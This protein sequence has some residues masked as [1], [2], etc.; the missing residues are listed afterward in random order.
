MALVRL[1]LDTRKASRNKNG[2]YPI[3][4]K[5]FHL[6]PR[7]IRLGHFTSTDGWDDKN[8]TLRKSVRA[9][10][11]Q[12]CWEIEEDIED[13][14]FKAKRIIRELGRKLEVIDVDRLVD[15]I[16]DKWDE[17]PDS[18]LRKRIENN[19]T[20]LTWAKVLNTR[21]RNANR[22]GTGRWY[23]AGVEA[24]MKFNNGRDIAL[25][26]INVTFL[27]NF[28]A[29][30]LGKGN[31]K[32][33][34]GIYLKAIRVIYNSAIAEDQFVPFKNAFKHYRIPPSTR[35]K[36]R[37]IL[38]EKLIKI[39]SLLYEKESP[40]WHAKNYALIMFYCRGMNFVDLVKIKVKDISDGRLYYGRSKTDDSFSVKITEELSNI[41]VYYLQGKKPNDYLLPTNYDGSTKHFQKYKSQRRRMNERLRIIAADAGIDG[42][43]TTYSIRHSWATIAKYMGISTEIISE[44]L[45][46]KSLKTTQIYLKSFQNEIL[47]EANERIVA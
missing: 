35:T 37:A 6:K 1:T 26:D 8:Y 43:F 2:L 31:S 28:E 18:Q 9:N 17:N 39:K 33:T 23:L 47:D 29:H 40:L 12:D 44:G 20:L 10:K 24:V 14:L 46:H 30:H 13:K 11:N 4:L 42:Q 41:L 21:K 16:K 34:I 45:G 32:N 15:C 5:V 3:V 22:P 19:M 7:L 36:K 25:Y 27:K 38:K